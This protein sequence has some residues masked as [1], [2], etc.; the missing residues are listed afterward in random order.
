[1]KGLR[2]DEL[3]AA[4]IR[5]NTFV[6][7]ANKRGRSDEIFDSEQAAQ[8]RVQNGRQGQMH[9]SSFVLVVCRHC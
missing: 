3:V 2:A 6:G 8:E 9:I 5:H 4:Q 7:L 1:L